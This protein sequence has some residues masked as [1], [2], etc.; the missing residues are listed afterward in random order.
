MLPFV[1]TPLARWYAKYQ[2]VEQ[3]L[4]DITKNMEAGRKEL[5]NDNITLL[6]D[7][8]VMRSL[9]FTL[10]DYIQVG[11]L[12]QQKLRNGIG[13]MPDDEPRKVFLQ[14]KILFPLNQRIM[15]L[16]Q[17]LA[18]NQQGYLSVEVIVENN[19]QLIRGV[20]RALTVTMTALGVAATLAIALKRQKKVL[21]ATD[22][23]NKT[24]GDML[25]QT[26]EQLKT[27]G[28]EIQKQASQANLDTEKVRLAFGNVLS[29]IE[30]L[31][32]FRVQALE[33]MQASIENLS[34]LTEEME[35]AISK[36]EQGHDVESQFL[37]T[38]E[39]TN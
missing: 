29:A 4:Q 18:V 15:D 21:D 20:D 35:K 30:D 31:A 11:I 23:L 12:V 14:E 2:T 5:E 34:T 19:K 28:V 32:Q 9:T 1:G 24:T 13:A 27:Q 10:D 7:Q 38:L 8:E 17:Q 39:A 37:I 26:S 22:A 3:V 25:V 16:Q 6:N 33:P 36:V